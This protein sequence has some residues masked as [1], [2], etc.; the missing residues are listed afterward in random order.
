[1]KSAMDG[2]KIYCRAHLLTRGLVPAPEPAGKKCTMEGCERCVGLAVLHLL[3]PLYF[4]L[5][6]RVLLISYR[7]GVIVMPRP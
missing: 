2:T 5:P 7:I 1:V 3:Q 4:A 6:L